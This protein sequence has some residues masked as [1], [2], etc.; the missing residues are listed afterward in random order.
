[1]SKNNAQKPQEEEALV[2]QQPESNRERKK[3]RKKE[4][5]EVRT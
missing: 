1:V 2:V 4:R 5:N 3:E